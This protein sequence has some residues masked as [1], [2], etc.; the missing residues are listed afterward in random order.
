MQFIHLYYFTSINFLNRDH[1]IAL[2]AMQKSA[3]QFASF[4]QA[5]MEDNQDVLDENDDS[6]PVTDSNNQNS[7]DQDDITC[8]ICQCAS[9][10][11]SIINEESP[12]LAI[13]CDNRKG[14]L[15]FSQRTRIC[16][17]YQKHKN[18]ITKDNLTT[19]AQCGTLSP[20][21]DDI[22]ASTSKPWLLDYSSIED[23]EKSKSEP[24]TD[25]L[26]ISM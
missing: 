3:Q 10:T 8:I 24:S 20:D 16:S 13:E 14:Y 19:T 2:A 11:E 1:T 18:D 26:H 6:H 25:D 9:M 22:T 7:A 12:L 21:S 23:T 4:S 15:G 5:N 17:G